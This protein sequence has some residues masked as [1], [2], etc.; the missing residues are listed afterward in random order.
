[1]NPELPLWIGS[2]LGMVLIVVLLIRQT[3]RRQHHHPAE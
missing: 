1:M 3:I 2:A